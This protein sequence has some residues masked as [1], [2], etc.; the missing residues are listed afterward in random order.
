MHP[1]KQQPRAG[2]DKLLQKKKRKGSL[3][4]KKQSITLQMKIRSGVK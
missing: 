2:P 1:N 3:Q 4:V